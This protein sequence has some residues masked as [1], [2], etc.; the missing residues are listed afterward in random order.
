MD[1]K[2]NLNYP[3]DAVIAWVDGHDELH[4][5]KMRPYLK[6]AKLLDNDNF[7]TRFDQVDEVKFAVDSI[8]KFAPY[9][10]TV[11]IVTD[12]QI[13]NFLKAAN[14]DKKYAKV[15]IVDH[16]IIFKGFESHLPTFNCLP[17]ETMLIKIPKL[18]EYFI[19]FNDD[20]FLIKEAKIS[21]FFVDRKPVLRGEWRKYDTEIWYKNLYSKISLLLGGKQ[22]KNTYGFKRSQQ[23]IACKLGFKKKYFKF[24]HTPAPMLK[25]TLENYFVENPEMREINIKHRFRHPE[26]FTFQGLANHLEIKNK[27]C[28]IKKDYQL[29]YFGSYKKPLI[30]YKFNLWLSD[31]NKNKLF[32][33]LQSL[34]QC[35][36]NKLAYILNWLI[37][38]FE[39]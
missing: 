19:Y 34:D 8:L 23:N 12:N 25:S 37:S 29:A 18:S 22:K 27:T 9:I 26:Q 11:F 10:R 15:Q 5:A 17:I 7:R 39:K 3:I 32:L 14:R 30:W 31:N 16:T 6:D 4:R 2:I 21:D 20:F 36:P 24:D 1:E 13:P 38:K 33:C 28:V 35:P